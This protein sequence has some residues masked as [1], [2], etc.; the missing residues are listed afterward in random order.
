M[1]RGPCPSLS[2]K[3][4]VQVELESL[5]GR[6]VVDVEIQIVDEM[7][8]VVPAGDRIE[9]QH[10]AI[11]RALRQRRADT[12]F[13]GLAIHRGR[14]N[15]LHDAGGWSSV[16]RGANLTGTPRPWREQVT[17][18]LPAG[19]VLDSADCGLCLTRHRHANGSGRDRA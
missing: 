12:E 4:L 7:G 10:I 14:G 3:G 8:D 15:V 1:P 19:H 11:V 18:R 2:T 9:V 13:S 17:A 16:T 5:R 6:R